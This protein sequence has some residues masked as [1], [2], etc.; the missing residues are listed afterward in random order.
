MASGLY[1]KTKKLILD[2]DVDLLAD[3]IKVVLVDTADYTVDLAADDFLAD[4]AEAG[5]VGTSGNLSGKTTTGGVFD[6]DDVTLSAVSGHE[7]EALVLYKDTGS[8]ATSPLIAYIE[9][10][11]VTPNGGDITVT[12][13]AGAN[14]IFAI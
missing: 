9:I 12:F 7:S 4:I 1:V 3:D 5:R 10:A 6:A 11:A 14:K 13:D 2:A 8:A